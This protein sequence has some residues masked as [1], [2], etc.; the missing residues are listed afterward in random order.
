[1]SVQIGSLSLY[2]WYYGTV[3]GFQ[4]GGGT[5]SNWFGKAK[6][7]L[8]PHQRKDGCAK[9]SWDPVGTYEKQT[10]GRVFAT[11]LAV[12]ILEQPYRHRKLGK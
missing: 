6:S 1:M 7:A 2:N 11:A 9:G 10:G 3:A 12:L 8:L 4:A 5:W